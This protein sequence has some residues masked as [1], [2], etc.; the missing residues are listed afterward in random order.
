MKHSDAFP[1]QAIRFALAEGRTTMAGLDAA[2][3]FWNPAVH[4]RAMNRR[5]AA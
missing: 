1:E 4:L 3:F 2:A 5:R